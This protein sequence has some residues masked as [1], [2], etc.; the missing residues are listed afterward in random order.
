MSLLVHVHR[1]CKLQSLV[2]DVVGGKE[3]VDVLV[4][5]ER[6]VLVWALK[7]RAQLQAVHHHIHLAGRVHEGHDL[8]YYRE[9]EPAILHKVYNFEVQSPKEAAYFLGSDPKPRSKDIPPDEALR[10]HE[11]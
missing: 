8:L 6:G 4:P 1:S 10:A 3:P 2:V 9:W 5:V 11:I 7:H